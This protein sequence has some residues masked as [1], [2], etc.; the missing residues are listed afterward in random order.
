MR[1]NVKKIIVVL[2][3]FIYIMAVITSVNAFAGEI[4]TFDKDKEITEVDNAINNIGGTIITII[5]V[6]SVAIAIV[7]LLVIGMRYMISA[8]GDRADIKKHAVAY[9]VGAFILF[10]VSGILTILTDFSSKITLS[11]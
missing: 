3:I 5:R 10:G 11:N 1:K 8:P 7:M 6:V 2:I 9:V 4:S